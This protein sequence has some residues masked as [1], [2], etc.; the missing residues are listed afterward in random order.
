VVEEVRRVGFDSLNLDL[1]YGLPRQTL[2]G[3]RATIAG[4]LT[5]DPDRLAVFRYAHVPTMRAHQRQS[6]GSIGTSW[7]TPS[8]QR[9]TCWPS[10]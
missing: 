10:G 5:L 7:A 6:V 8:S 4:V 2:E 9:I 3:F 1:I